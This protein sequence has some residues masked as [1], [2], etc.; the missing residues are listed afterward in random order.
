MQKGTSPAH[1]IADR[2][3]PTFDL[4][5]RKIPSH[6]A[7]SI[8]FPRFAHV[9][10]V[11]LLVSSDKSRYLYAKRGSRSL[12]AVFPRT[13]VRAEPSGREQEAGVQAVMESR[14]TNQPMP[15]GDSSSHVC[16]E[17]CRKYGTTRRHPRPRIR[18]PPKRHHTAMPRWRF[19][20]V[21]PPC[22]G[23]RFRC[24]RYVA[25]RNTLWTILLW[26]REDS[27]RPLQF[28]YHSTVFQKG[29]NDESSDEKECNRGCRLRLRHPDMGPAGPG[30][31][32]DVLLS[33][34]GMRV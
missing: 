29:K 30:R 12:F 15:C 32:N 20:N 22:A 3:T 25:D 16:A 18:A 28:L 2:R 23:T 27:P 4:T 13:I 34:Q 24:Q 31:A 7:P 19:A 8:G 11:V 26:S 1:L 14:Q 6:P 21:G 9:F 33:R 10:S 5:V 17:A